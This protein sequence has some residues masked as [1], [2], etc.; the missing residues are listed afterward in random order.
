[1]ENKPENEKFKLLLN[2]QYSWP[3]EYTFKFI[4]PVNKK[5]EVMKVIPQ[6]KFSERTS[7]KGK[8]SALTVRLVVSSS[9]EVI[10]IYHKVGNIDGVIA[11]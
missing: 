2:E 6:Q 8:Y 7:K 1:M 3:A 5:D 4:V 10:D 11:L 9:D